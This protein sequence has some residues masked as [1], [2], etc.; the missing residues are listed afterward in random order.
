MNKIKFKKSTEIK[1]GWVA[2]L[3]LY[4]WVTLTEYHFT[5]AMYKNLEKMIKEFFPTAEIEIMPWDACI[6][7]I[8]LKN[9]ADNDYFKLW[10]NNGIEI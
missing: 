1:Y 7:F 10:S 5:V 4:E 8:K 9:S 6:V 2:T 3:D